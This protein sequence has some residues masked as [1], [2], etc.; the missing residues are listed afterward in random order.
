MSLEDC[1]N[2]TQSYAAVAIHKEQTA[3][4]VEAIAL[5]QKAKRNI[6]MNPEFK[7]ARER[8][9]VMDYEDRHY[10]E[11]LLCMLEQLT[12][13]IEFLTKEIAQQE[14]AYKDIQNTQKSLVT[15]SSTGSANVA[16]ISGNGPGDRSF[17]DDGNYSASSFERQNR[18]APL[19]SKV[20]T[21]T[22]KPNIPRT[23]MSSSPT[24][25]R[26]SLR[27]GAGELE[28]HSAVKSAKKASVKSKSVL[29]PSKS[30]A[31]TG[32]P[33]EVSTQNNANRAALL[34]WGS[35]NP[36]KP[37]HA[38]PPSY[39]SSEAAQASRSSF[40]VERHRPTPDNSAVIEAA[41]RTYSS[42]SSSSSPF[43]KKT[44]SHLPNRTT[45]VPSIS[46]QL[47]KSSTSIATVAP[48]LAS[49]SSVTKS[50]SPT[51]QPAPRAQ[52][53]STET[54]QD[55]DFLTPPRLSVNNPFLSDLYPASEQ[56]LSSCEEKDSPVDGD[57]FF[58]H[59]NEEEIIEK[60]LQSTSISAMTSE[61]QEQILR[62]CPDIDEE[63]G[64]SILREIVV[65]GDE[66]HWD[67]I[68]G[69]EFAKHS[70]KEAVVYPFLRPDLFQGL[71]EPARGMLLFGPPG[72]GKTMLARA[73]ATESR[74]VFFSISASS[75]TSKFL[76]ESEKLVRALFTLAKK[77]SPSIIFVDEIDS[78][79][80]ARS[81][82]G[83]EHETSR[84][85]KTE[86][87]IQW[88]SLARAAASRQT[89]D[90]P[91]VLVLAATNLPWCIDDAARR[92]FVRRTYIP[93]PDETTR[94]LHLNNLLKYQKHSLS[95]EDIEAIVKATEYYSGSDLTA[96][97]KDAAMGPLR[98]LGESLLFTKMESIRPIN[99]D[100]FKTSIKVIRPSVNLQGLERYSEWDK[101]FGSQGH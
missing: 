30:L 52:S 5:F 71:R 34:A 29:P 55:L 6:L 41:R 24:A 25:S 31:R 98:S 61:K 56:G 43:K 9:H 91:R 59:T 70:L 73:V 48:S 90:H 69:L 28:T 92:R 99:L 83:N 60:Q 20:T 32:L 84:R 78:L 96:L 89:A 58:N 35:L 13:R 63:L 67:D 101:E 65:S 95:L 74:S 94:R 14:A 22:L 11:T 26:T 3:D 79:L 82:D 64:K 57:E 15:Q 80:S 18:T 17:I 85:I 100:D 12:I 10:V 97:A 27:K 38:L 1:Y 81:S 21:A 49:V 54:A 42:I 93:L 44:Q 72:T 53:A 50:P 77:L 62:E 33:A 8:L 86:F 87:L 19:Q 37:K 45:E 16:Y 7:Y 39:I 46:K 66:V 68:S 4:Y 47:S 88:S 36:S 75:L 76:G 40:Q 2:V 51:P 23:S